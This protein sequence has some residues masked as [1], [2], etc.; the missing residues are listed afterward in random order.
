MKSHHLSRI[1][2]ALVIALGLSTSAMAVE[3]SSSMSGKIISPTG[4]PAAHTKIIITHIPTG[5]VKTVTTNDTGSYN[6]RGLRVGGPY[7]VVIDSDQF[8]DQQ[9]SNIFLEVGQPYRLSTNL[10]PDDIEKIVVTGSR[11]VGFTN[12]GT[13]GTWGADDI[14]N[15]AGGNRDLKDILRSNPLVSVSNDSDA[16]M[17]I[18]GSNPKYN[19]FTV[20][21]VRQNDDF[22]LNGNGYPTQRSPIS[23]DA[24]EQVS[25]ETT[26]FSVKNGGFS[27]GQ[28]NAVTKSGTNEFHGTVYFDKTDSDWAGTPVN[29]DGDEI[30]LDFSSTTYAA[31]LGGPII[32]D[33]LFFFGSYE[34]FDKPTQIEW[35]PDGSSAPN[36]TDI[37]VA[38]YQR[39]IDAA[40][41]VYG[42]DAGTWDQQ[43][44]QNDE[45][46][47]FKLDWNI[48][49]DHRA[50]FTYQNTEGNVTR[51]MSTSR[52]ELKLS[53][54]WYNKNETLE[55]LAGQLYSTWSDDF[56]T[57]V[58]V[59]YKKV[60]TDQLPA[61]KAYGDISIR[62]NS[63]DI[64]FGPDKYRHG[65]KLA[66]D[67]LSMRFL[68]EYLY[69]D[70]QITFGAEYD[71]VDVNNLFAPSSLGEWEFDSIED[72][73]NRQASDFTYQN[74]YTNNVDDAY[75][76]FTF[77]TTTFFAEDSY[78]LT[79]D[80]LI[81][82]GLRYEV[83]STN[84]VPSNNANFEQRYGF[85]NSATLDGET[86]LLPRI[87]FNWDFS[88][89]IVISGGIGRFSG[90]KPN[91][92]LSNSY[93]NDGITYVAA[94][95]ENDFLDNVD[96]TQIPQGVLN[97]MAA[98]DGYVN[99]T[100]PN[101]KI[102][103]DWRTTLAVD[104]TFSVPNLGDDWL[105]SAEY[106]YI[107]KE[108]DPFWKDL[109]RKVVGQTG[110]GQNI[111]QATD[112]LTGEKTQRYDLLLTNADN[113]GRSK[114]FTTSLS[115]YFDNG[116][117]FNLSYTNQDITEGTSGG[118]STASS[119]FKYPYTTDRN[120]AEVG[121][122][123][124][125]VEHS[126]K[127][128][129]NY[130]IE[131]V[132]NYATRFNLFFERRSGR[133]FSWLLGSYKDDDLGDQKAFY[134]VNA[135][136][137]YI[138]TGADDPNVVL[139]GMSWDEFSSYVGQAGLS[140]YAGGF[141]PK[142]SARAPWI[143]TL[144][145]TIT[146]EIPGFMPGHNGEIFFNVNNLLNMI[147]S[148][149]GKSLRSRFGNGTLVDFDV[150][151]E[152]RYVYSKPFGDFD[153]ATWDTFDTTKSTWSV[154]M[155]VRYKF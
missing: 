42:V 137:P 57:E 30:E 135:Y 83:I 119:N 17:S 126:I 53:S 9:F 25:V 145:L 143:N 55:S 85:S 148:S 5:T 138:P 129:V 29:P 13:T 133:P 63:G 54:Q 62:A 91:V 107:K 123:A 140:G 69:Q 122:A 7:R 139:D 16:S 150:D 47:L 82:A 18:A 92:W 1:A 72:F 37:T 2:G 112:N 111:Y 84:D 93:S 15:A 64:A 98:G 33:K 35:G 132:E 50:A 144:D 32:A 38:D 95:N 153:P 142:S 78:Y 24:I 131:F 49:E 68:G 26:P 90:G 103:S 152:G 73:E 146:Q 154:K 124:Y 89:D 96:I 65:N 97:G 46:I 27:G 51:N 74:A 109:T 118:S 120:R 136:L 81:N 12:T 87:S 106:L 59:A 22:G 149:A 134:K 100:D 79:D 19:S 99:A 80:F 102:T 11:I 66:N 151:E 77:V 61:T 105:W 10:E 128:S 8:K 116:L 155:G 41:S 44:K 113:N 71:S 56:T 43:P 76:S 20:D 67:T 108:N 60:K 88:E 45:K 58:K 125:Q 3:T 48:N 110:A 52:R 6:L 70:H 75:A 40:Q 94:N 34:K 23:I 104:Y 4:S 115:K 31:T 141:A 121:T 39:V 127:L 117:G 86:I 147:D 114:I 101:F 28:I 36:P 21:G 14:V 130:Q